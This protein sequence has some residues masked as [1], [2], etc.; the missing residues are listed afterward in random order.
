MTVPFPRCGG[1][2]SP[3]HAEAQGCRLPAHRQGGCALHQGGQDLCHSWRRVQE[4]AGAA[5]AGGEQVRL[6]SV[7]RGVCMVGHSWPGGAVSAV[8]DTALPWWWL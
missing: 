2:V 1:G 5:A 8:A 6:S 7:C 4:G 3:A